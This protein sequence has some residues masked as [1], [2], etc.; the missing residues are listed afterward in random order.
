MDE[1]KTC[2]NCGNLDAVDGEVLCEAGCID[3]P[4]RFQAGQAVVVECESWATK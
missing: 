1:K 2:I 3:F 4:S